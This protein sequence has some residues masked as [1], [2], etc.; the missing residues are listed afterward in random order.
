MVKQLS[1]TRYNVGSPGTCMLGVSRSFVC[2]P[3]LD[4]THANGG[5]GAKGLV[6]KILFVSNPYSYNINFNPFHKTNINE[7]RGVLR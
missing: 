3:W 2:F 1:T 7:I 4:V 5:S 6:Q